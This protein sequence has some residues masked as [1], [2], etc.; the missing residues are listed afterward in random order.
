MNVKSLILQWN[1][2]IRESI[3]VYLFIQQNFPAKINDKFFRFV[4]KSFYG[5]NNA[6]LREECKNK[7]FK[8]L[9]S[10]ENSLQKILITLYE[11]P[12]LK[13]YNSYQ[14]SFATK[15]L[16]TLDNSLPIYD[17][18]IASLFKL[19]P[20]KSD[21]TRCIKTYNL[22]K[23]KFGLLLKDSQIQEHIHK[24]KKT[25]RAEK[26]S[27]AKILDFMLWSIGKDEKDRTKKLKL[28]K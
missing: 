7:Y 24:I 8:L 2:N 6:G 11:Y 5:L 15:L 16:H 14:L 22:L 17:S 9:E 10:K 25:Y 21:L 27:D 28:K 20:K 1:R 13:G 3:E 4:Y 19:P 26:I 18:N 23:E 12:T